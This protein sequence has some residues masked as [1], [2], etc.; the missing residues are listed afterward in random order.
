MLHLFLYYKTQQNNFLFDWFIVR[1][2]MAAE[3]LQLLAVF[4]KERFLLSFTDKNN[5]RAKF[6]FF[7]L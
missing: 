5:R 3:N 7:I 4:E 2:I 1:K 6:L